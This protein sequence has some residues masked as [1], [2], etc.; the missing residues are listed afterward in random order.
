M[1]IQP[2]TTIIQVELSVEE[3]KKL[4]NA[5]GDVNVRQHYGNDFFCKLGNGLNEALR[6][7]Q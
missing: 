7:L 6:G 2:I 1:N 5:C 3:A 4:R